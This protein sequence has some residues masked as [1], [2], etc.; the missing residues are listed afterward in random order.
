MPRRA[1]HRESGCREVEA[2]VPPQPTGAVC[3]FGQG[4]EC[5]AQE[6]LRWPPDLGR[7]A[8]GCAVCRREERL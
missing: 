8:C 1:K 6:I 2:T 3:I 5:L 7:Y 4:G